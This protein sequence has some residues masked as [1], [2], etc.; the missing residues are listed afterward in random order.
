MDLRE[1][2]SPANSREYLMGRALGDPGGGSSLLFFLVCVEDGGFRWLAADLARGRLG[3]ASPR[4]PP[5]LWACLFV[6]IFSIMDHRSFEQKD[7]EHVSL[8]AGS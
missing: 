4:G 3:L 7:S 8:Q 6:V 1:G 2:I 5:D